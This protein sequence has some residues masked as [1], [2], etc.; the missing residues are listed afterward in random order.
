MNTKA[1]AQKTTFF[2]AST[3]LDSEPVTMPQKEVSECVAEQLHPEI[4]YV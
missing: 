4:F 2:L 3:I 1:V